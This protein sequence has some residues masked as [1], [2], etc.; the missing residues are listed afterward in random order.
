MTRMLMSDAIA[1]GACVIR[2]VPY[3]I[4]QDDYGCAVGMATYAAKGMQDS[5]GSCWPWAAKKLETVMPCGCD[6]MRYPPNDPAKRGAYPILV[7]SDAIAHLFNEHVMDHEHTGKAS[8][9]LE[10]LIDWVREVEPRREQHESG[11]EEERLVFS[12]Y[13][14]TGMAE[15]QRH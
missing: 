1:L 6:S 7:Y 4:G 5:A 9:T 14:L 11:T 8:W 15:T 3:T 2:A 12:R 13:E 10:Q